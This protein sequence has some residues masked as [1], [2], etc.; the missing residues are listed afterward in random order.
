MPM[1]TI[2]ENSFCVQPFEVSVFAGTRQ[3]ERVH[4]QALDVVQ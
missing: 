4:V 2:T 1:Q 3:P